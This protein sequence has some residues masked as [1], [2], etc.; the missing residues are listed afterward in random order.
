MGIFQSDVT[1]N[2]KEKALK[3][4]P[5]EDLNAR[6]TKIREY[7]FEQSD[8]KWEARKKDVRTFGTWESFLQSFLITCTRWDVVVYLRL[9]HGR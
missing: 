3:L 6:M 2:A 5:S 4:Y 9:F 8:K 1:E 7:D